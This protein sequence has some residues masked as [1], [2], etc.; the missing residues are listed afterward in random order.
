MI[1][2]ASL[3]SGKPRR[4]TRRA[5][6]LRSRLAAVFYEDVTPPIKLPLNPRAL[7]TPG[8]SILT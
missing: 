6:N 3:S 7:A 1:T 4:I 5:K 2:A 8:L